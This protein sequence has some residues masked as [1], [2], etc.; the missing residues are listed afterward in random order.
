LNGRL[1][2]AYRRL[3]IR[4]AD[5]GPLYRWATHP[6]DD[7]GWFLAPVVQAAVELLVSPGSRYIRE[8]AGHP[9]GWIFLDH[10]RNHSRRW[11]NMAGC[12]NRAKARRH[13]E[14]SKATR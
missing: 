8:C 11:C 10:S 6:D 4:P 2:F 3:G 9:C 7:L 14:R 12:G 5:N 13:Y 1:P